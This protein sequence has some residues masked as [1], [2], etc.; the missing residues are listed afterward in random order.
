[1]PIEQ[2]PNP[3]DVAVTNE[4]QTQLDQFSAAMLILWTKKWSIVAVAVVTALLSYGALRLFFREEFK[5]SG[6]IYSTRFN[7]SDDARYPDTVSQIATSSHLLDKVRIAY[8]D[9]FK[10][11][12]APA[13]EDFVKQFKVKT[14]VIQDTAVKKEFSPVI[15]LNVQ[16]AGREETR[17]LMETWLRVLVEDQGN[18]ATEE[19]KIRWGAAKQ[20]IDAIAIVA[21]AAEKRQADAAAEMVWLEKQL[22]EQMNRLAPGE[23]IR[24]LLPKTQ[25]VNDAASIAGSNSISFNVDHT[26]QNNNANGTPGLLAR[27]EDAKLALAL[28]QD[29]GDTVSVKKKQKL[30]EL[31]SADISQTSQSIAELQLRVADSARRVSTSTREVEEARGRMR[32]AHLFAD[33]IEAIGSTHFLGTGADGLPVAGDIRAIAGP[34]V[35]DLRAWPKRTVLSVGVGV[36]CGAFYCL[37]LLMALWMNALAAVANRGK[38]RA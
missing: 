32:E 6:Q 13:I 2:M 9:H 5:A 34:V 15:E 18:Y 1:M 28:A 12:R 36:A 8:K 22:A 24:P 30:V 29:E 19:A 17:F 35:P 31:L 4:P 16:S 14:E 20:T 11:S 25:S 38:D 27:L 23:L 37:W 33:R 3:E 10:L 21:G 26:V 7:A